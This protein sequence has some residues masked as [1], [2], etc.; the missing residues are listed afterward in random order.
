SWDDLMDMGRMN[1]GDHN[2]RFC[3]STFACNTCQEVNG[4]SKLHGK[5]SQAM[6]AGIWKG[7]YPEENHV[8]YVTNGVHFQTWC[9]SEWQELYSRYFDSHFL[10][11]QSNASIWEKIY[12]VPDEEI[13]ATRQALKK[14]L[15][16]YIRKSFREDWL[17]RQGDPSRVVSVM[18]K[19][20]PNALLIGFG[21]RFATYKRA[22]L[23]FT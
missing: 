13:W 14:K 11:D 3:M 22:H 21:R 5:V 8:G 2:E 23:L 10:A 15:V 4:V 20:N 7:Y 19:I 6:F 16:D 17:K 18:E 12:Q 1:P 9:A